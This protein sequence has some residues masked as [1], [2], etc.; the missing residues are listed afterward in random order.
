[1]KIDM[2]LC[3]TAKPIMMKRSIHMTLQPNEPKGDQLWYDKPASR[4][5][6]AL[7]IGNGRLGGMVFGKIE[8]ELIQLNE[9]SVWYGGPRERDNPEAARFFPQIRQ[10]VMEGKIQEAQHLAKLALTPVPKYFGPYQPLGDLNLLFA[11]QGKTDECRRDLVLD[12]AIASVTYRLNGI[13]YRREIF[14]SAEDQVLVVHLTA[15]APGALTFSANLTRRPFEHETR[16]LGADA[17]AISGQCGPDGIRYGAMIRVLAEGGTV[18]GIGD[19]ISVTGADSATLLLAANTTFREPDPLAACRRQI[20]AARAKGYN[21]LKRDHV[22]EYRS[23]YR[24]VQI[25]LGDSG[26]AALLPTDQ[27]LKRV[28]EGAEDP[29]L[30]ALYFQY[31]RYLLISSSRPGTLP[32]NLQGIWND[33]F[34]PPWECNYTT[35]INLEMN[36]WPAEVCNLAECHEPL[37]DFIDRLRING[38]ITAREL[39]G[40]GGFVAHHNT[41]L[42]ADT[43]INGM[44]VRA[45]VWPTSGAW[46]ALHLWEHYRFGLDNGFLSARAYPT[47]KEAALFF[48]DYMVEDGQ[49][50]LVTGPS[51]SPENR[52]F[53]SDGSIGYL[54]MGPAMDTQIVRMLFESCIEAA[55]LLGIDESFAD[56]LRG[57]LAKLPKPQIGSRG[58]LLEWLE[59]Y[60]E[61]E[62]GHRH[63]SHLFALHPGEQI[64]VEDT[65]ELAQA[66]RTTLEMRLANGGGHTGWSRAWM[67]NFWARLGDAENAYE[68]V[69]A[70]L[71][72]STSPNLLDEHPPFQIDGNFGGAAGIAEMLLQSHGGVI[73][74]LPALPRA[75]ADGCVTGLRARGAFE[76]D[77]EWRGGRLV[78][79]VL[80][81]KKDGIC[82]IRVKDSLSVFCGDQ[83]VE[84]QNAGSSVIEFAVKEGQSYTVLPASS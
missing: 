72:K 44:N 63:I 6:Q 12:T 71:R 62:P 3:E 2:R 29:G 47:M 37:F 23:Y 59:E 22:A 61:P 41:N 81:A 27:R 1:M 52:Y 42:W 66:A 39:Y 19:Y 82:R 73:R 60:G 80:H 45:A 9:D 75:W 58:Q 18:H 76:T 43:L 51:V 35:N 24:R 4:W 10:M 50:R 55:E 31:G 17:M 15:D 20:E 78:R 64:T 40:C 57:A 32:A 67:I 34:K 70:L 48:L 84:A 7:P 38:R 46:L 69:L 25:D 68:H 77:L 28:Q 79:A 33:Q 14:S 16:R 5:T 53:L 26:N 36:Y 21:R 65:P 13:R 74:L 83:P 11:H 30:A 49:G 56:R 8:E 54:C